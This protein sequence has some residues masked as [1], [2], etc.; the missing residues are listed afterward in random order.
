MRK[1]EYKQWRRFQKGTCNYIPICI[2]LKDINNPSKCIEEFIDKINEVDES[3]YDSAEKKDKK[4]RRFKK[5]LLVNNS[6]NEENDHE[7]LIILDQYDELP[8]V[9][10]ILEINKFDDQWSPK[11]KF[12]ICKNH[13]ENNLM[14]KQMLKFREDEDPIKEFRIA[15][16]TQ[17]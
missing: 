3:G 13:Q 12:I 2:R 15:D 6:N 10:N 14:S 17:Q 1:L 16:I 9:R 4:L 11:T 8:Q 5:D 7:F